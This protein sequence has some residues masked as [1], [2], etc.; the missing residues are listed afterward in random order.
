MLLSRSTWGF[1]AL[2]LSF[3]AGAKGNGP[4][5]LTDAEIDAQNK[6][7]EAAA[8]HNAESMLAAF[9]PEGRAPAA[10]L[11]KKDASGTMRN[12]YYPKGRM[13]RAVENLQVDKT[14][15]Q[16]DGKEVASK[17][18]EN[19]DF[20][21]ALEEFFDKLPRR[22]LLGG[23]K[24][25]A[26]AID[27]T[28]PESDPTR[29][30]LQVDVPLD[31][32]HTRFDRLGKSV[33]AAIDYAYLSNG[34]GKG[35][36]WT[37]KAKKGMR[38][39][40]VETFMELKSAGAPLSARSMKAICNWLQRNGIQAPAGT[41]SVKSIVP[42]AT[43]DYELFGYDLDEAK[44]AALSYNQ[45]VGT[46]Y[47]AIETPTTLRNDIDTTLFSSFNVIIQ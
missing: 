42:G 27:S 17:E 29:L 9:E 37:A 1:W 47:K 20:K 25:M 35:Y 18:D 13:E 45:A 26:C 11:L 24:N 16:V 3:S 32:S 36:G 46:S 30:R 15:L 5:P 23:L 14:S 22:A 40:G 38:E 43:Q 39:N 4:K 31:P 44:K 28:K 6:K 21:L 33:P 8:V 12:V 34:F 19:R 10:Y 7:A 41:Y 2:V